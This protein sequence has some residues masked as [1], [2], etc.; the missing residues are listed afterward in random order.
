MRRLQ[1]MLSI[2]TKGG[3][4]DEPWR[5]INRHGAGVRGG[6]VCVRRPG[7]KLTEQRLTGPQRLTRYGHGTH[8]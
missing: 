6:I 3:R 2:S 7:V 1:R 5:I 4:V 8:F